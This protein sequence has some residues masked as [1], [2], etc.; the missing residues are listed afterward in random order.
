MGCRSGCNCR[1][2]NSNISYGYNKSCSKTYA[3]VNFCKDPFSYVKESFVIPAI[4][5]ILEIVVTDSSRLYVGQGIGIGGNYF[6]V[7]AIED[8]NNISIFHNGNADVGLQI[9]ALNPAYGCYNYPILFAVPGWGDWE[10][11]FSSDSGSFTETAR[12]FARYLTIND[13]LFFQIDTRGTV[14]GTPTFLE[15]T[16]P[17]IPG[18]TVTS[19][20]GSGW[21]SLGGYAGGWFVNGPIISVAQN[22]TS[23]PW[24]AGDDRRFI[25]NGFLHL[26]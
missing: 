25:I 22:A 3:G 2:C 14:V 26:V 6:Y 7:A 10:P 20:R 23:D 17:D 12:L 13:I 5:T 1:S 8:T 24:T 19:G 15:F 9:T 16:P 21:T 18:K 11:E 4:G